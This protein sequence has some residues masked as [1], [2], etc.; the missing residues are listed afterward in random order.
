MEKKQLVYTPVF[1]PITMVKNLSGET[2]DYQ[3]ILV[4]SKKK[5]KEKKKGEMKKKRRKK[6]NNE[7]NG[8]KR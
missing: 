4:K 6:E 5:K 2:G 3:L 8:K 7:K 1:F